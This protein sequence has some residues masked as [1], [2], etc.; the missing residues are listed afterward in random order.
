[1]FFSSLKELAGDSA[2]FITQCDC[3]IRIRKINVLLDKILLL[4]SS[5]CLF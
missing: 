4:L 3:F 2:F 1:M 5:N